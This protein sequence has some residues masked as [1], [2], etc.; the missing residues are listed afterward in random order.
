MLV[1]IFGHYVPVCLGALGA[2][3]AVILFGAMYVGTATRPFGVELTPESSAL[4]FPIFPTA[5]VA[6]VHWALWLP[7]FVWHSEDPLCRGASPRHHLSPVC[8]CGLNH[9]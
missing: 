1:R 3:E 7:V 6:S 4:V 5:V 9:F 2:T 8:I